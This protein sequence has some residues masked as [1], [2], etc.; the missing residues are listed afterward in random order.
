MPQNLRDTAEV[1]KE[2]WEYLKSLQGMVSTLPGIIAAVDNWAD[3]LR[4]SSA[5]KPLVYVLAISL[6]VYVFLSEVARYIRTSTAS[7]EFG[8]MGKR[9]S[10]HLIWFLVIAGL[11]WIG[12]RYFEMNLPGQLWLEEAAL[13][14]FAVAVALA[15][16]EITRALAIHSLRIYISK[17][18]P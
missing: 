1:L 15:F 5:I 7:P 17:N 16:A 11:Y 4:I 13:Y 9:G 6:I 2:V 12:V 8:Q 3:L 18:R 14:G 10:V